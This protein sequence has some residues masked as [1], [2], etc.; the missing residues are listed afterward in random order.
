MTVKRAL[1]ML[2]DEGLIARKRGAGTFVKRQPQEMNFSHGAA[3][4]SHLLGTAANLRIAGV[5]LK[6]QLVSFRSNS[7]LHLNY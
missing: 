1:D 7:L 2:V 4:F 6:T 5:M 3:S